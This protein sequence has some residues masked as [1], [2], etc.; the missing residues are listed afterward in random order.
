MQAPV[1]MACNR[2]ISAESDSRLEG[3]RR[4]RRRVGC[5]PGFGSLDQKLQRLRLRVKCREKDF[6]CVCTRVNAQLLFG[7]SSRCSSDA[8]IQHGSHAEQTT[9]KRRQRGV[10]GSDK[11]RNSPRDCED[12]SMS[13]QEGMYDRTFVLIQMD[14][15]IFW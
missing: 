7:N 5:V 13:A 9:L 3:R 1:A 2:I 10:V 14:L 6:L 11:L 12:T 15:R 4:T 8:Y